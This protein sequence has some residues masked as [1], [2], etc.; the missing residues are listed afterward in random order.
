MEF[1]QAAADSDDVEYIDIWVPSI[2]E[3]GVEILRKGCPS[4]SKK[5]RRITIN[6]MQNFSTREAVRA[7]AHWYPGKVFVSFGLNN[8]G[9]RYRNVLKTVPK[10]TSAYPPTLPR[11]HS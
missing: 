7:L 1:L 5:L 2:T 11:P 10:P 9:K 6:H 3:A 4:L 8:H